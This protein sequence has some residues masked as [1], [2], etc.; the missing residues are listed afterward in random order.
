MVTKRGQEGTS[1]YK[2]GQE[3][4]CRVET[5]SRWY[6]GIHEV[7]LRPNCLKVR[8]DILPLVGECDNVRSVNPGT[9]T[10]AN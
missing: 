8:D 2:R 10:S 5:H 7:F 9:A 6:R 3:L 4:S 1:R